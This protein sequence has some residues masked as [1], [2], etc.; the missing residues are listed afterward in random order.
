MHHTRYTR[1]Q[2]VLDVDAIIVVKLERSGLVIS[3]DR[4]ALQNNLRLTQIRAVLF[5]RVGPSII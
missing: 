3:L 1:L 5:S 4:H 2:Y